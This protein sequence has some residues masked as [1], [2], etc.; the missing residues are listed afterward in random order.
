[1]TRTETAEL[2]ELNMF[3]DALEERAAKV[4]EKKKVK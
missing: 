1:M 3:P 4:S 2:Q